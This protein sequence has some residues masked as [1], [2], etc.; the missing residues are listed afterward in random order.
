MNFGDIFG[1]MFRDA[2]GMPTK[3]STYNVRLGIYDEISSGVSQVEDNSISYLEESHNVDWM[4]NG[5][6]RLKLE[7][8]FTK[9]LITTGDYVYSVAQLDSERKQILDDF[10]STTDLYFV[11]AHRNRLYSIKR[12]HQR[13]AYISN[14]SFDSWFDMEEA[15]EIAN[16]A[17]LQI[18]TSDEY[19]DAK[20]IAEIRD[21]YMR[22]RHEKRMRRGR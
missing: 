2:T 19:V 5:A 14:M 11:T 18:R 6:S 4:L 1:Q 16:L 9:G 20:K 12:K 10:V 3:V 17:A 22:A 8:D 7:G 21:R 15:R 13:D